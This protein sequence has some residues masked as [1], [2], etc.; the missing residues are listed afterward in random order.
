MSGDAKGAMQ[1]TFCCQVT[2]DSADDEVSNVYEFRKKDH[3][4]HLIAWISPGGISFELIVI[5]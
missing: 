4:K 5:R 1:I 3:G 2:I